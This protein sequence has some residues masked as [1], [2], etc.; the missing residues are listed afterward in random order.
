[1]PRT[2]KVIRGLGCG[3]TI[4]ITTVAHLGRHVP[5]VVRT[6]MIVGGH[7]C[8]VVGCHRRGYLERDHCEVDYAIGGATAWWNLAWLCAVHLA[9]R[10]EA[11]SSAQPTR[12]PANERSARPTTPAAHPLQCHVDER[13]SAMRRAGA[14]REPERGRERMDNLRVGTRT[15]RS[16]VRV[17]RLKKR[18]VGFVV[19]AG[20]VVLLAACGSSSS[21]ASPAAAPTNSSSGPSSTAAATADVM[22]AS[23][24][25]LGTVLVDSAGKTLYMLKNAAGAPVACTGQCLTF[26]PPLLL[27]AGSTSATGATGVTGL[28]TV[29]AGGG[30]QVTENGAPLYHFSG[31]S[32]AGDANGDGI[33]SFGGV[34]HVVKSSASASAPAPTNAPA[35]AATTT[36]SAYGY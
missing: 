21:T 26:W 34:W 29:S 1:L 17:E 3:A 32:A 5:A 8:E 25:K 30:T 6:A 27:P 9:G 15:E 12:R 22:V 19:A 14:Y 24:A 16:S 28:G 4:D 18:G 33:S 11:G 35:P 7:E 10:P 31:D 20:A 2:S 13:R 36:T 23:N